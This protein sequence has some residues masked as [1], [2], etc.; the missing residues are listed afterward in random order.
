VLVVL[1]VA[2]VERDGTTSIDQ[3]RWVE[4]ALEM[5]WSPVR[6]RDGL[7]AS[8]GVWRDDE[9]GGALVMD[10]PVVIHY[11]TTPQAIE[12]PKSLA[13]LGAFCRKMVREARQGEVG[14]VVGCEYF[15][16]RDLAED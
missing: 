13:S 1:F 14:L 2:S 4:A 12:E 5:F 15:A 7:P 11:Y 8:Q 9:R 3:Q 16:I 6:R 10:E